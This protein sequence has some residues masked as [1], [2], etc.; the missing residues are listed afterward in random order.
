MMGNFFSFFRFRSKATDDNLL[1]TKNIDLTPATPTNTRNSGF[2]DEL[3]IIE[4]G[5][6]LLGDS[7]STISTEIRKE[8]TLKEP[9]SPRT[10]NKTPV[11]MLQSLRQQRM[12]KS[13]N[14][15]ISL[16]PHTHTLFCE[17]KVNKLMISLTY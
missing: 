15:A 10:K 4:T 1:N 11:A 3:V 8:K 13:I 16:V 6:I 14:I 2:N 7:D 5:E 9:T 17:R 12:N